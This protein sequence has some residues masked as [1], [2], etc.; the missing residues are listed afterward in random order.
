VAADP[1]SPKISFDRINEGDLGSET[2][3]LG[4]EKGTAMNPQLATVPPRD[5]PKPRKDPDVPPMR[6]LVAEC[7]C[8]DFCERDHENE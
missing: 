4:S 8:P 2:A 3:D 1:R 6:A 7:T 5:P